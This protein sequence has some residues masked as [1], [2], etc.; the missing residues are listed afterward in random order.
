MS[1]AKSIGYYLSI[2]IKKLNVL[3]SA[4]KPWS[5][6]TVVRHTKTFNFNVDLIGST[7]AIKK[8]E[9]VE[10]FTWLGVP[11]ISLK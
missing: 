10:G 3:L 5:H 8:Q 6:L 9:V 2:H 7:N 4:C 1:A 11:N